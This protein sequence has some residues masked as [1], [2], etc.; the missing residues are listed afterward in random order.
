MRAF[1]VTGLAV[2]ASGCAVLSTAPIIIWPSS[3]T[4]RVT[5]T[6]KLEVT[7]AN[8][9]TGW[10]SSDT[11]VASVLNGVVTGIKSGQ[12]TVQAQYGSTPGADATITV[13]P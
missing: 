4:I 12:V 1:C 10:V 9:V 3:T 7:Y 6:L 13:I 2:L 5:E 11:S 8:E